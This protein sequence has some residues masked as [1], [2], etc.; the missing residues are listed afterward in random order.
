MSD[1]KFVLKDGMRFEIKPFNNGEFLVRR[2]ELGGK[3]FSSFRTTNHSAGLTSEALIDAYIKRIKEPLQP[4][5][6][7]SL[8]SSAIGAK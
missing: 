4:S 8:V 5:K 6:L 7:S 2:F 3:T 1:S